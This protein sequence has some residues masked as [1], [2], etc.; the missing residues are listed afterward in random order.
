MKNEQ[1]RATRDLFM[2]H[3]PSKKHETAVS[4][5]FKPSAPWYN[6]GIYHYT[7]LHGIIIIPYI[8]T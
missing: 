1:T 5:M 6:T 3:L 8:G 7:V 2:R 4:P